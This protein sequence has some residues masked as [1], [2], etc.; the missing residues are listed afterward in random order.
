MNGKQS[1]TIL[2]A[3]DHQLFVDGLVRILEEDGGYTVLGTC[4]SGQELLHLLNDEAPN[5]VMLDIQLG[6]MN[7][8]ELCQTIRLRFPEV[9]VLFISMFES[10][11]IIQEGE[12]AGASGFIPK[13]YD[14]NQVKEVIQRVLA[15][16]PVFMKA[17]APGD[18]A[19]PET[20]GI[21]L[22]TR[23]EKEIIAMIRRGLTSRGIAEALN[24]SEYTI[25]TH[26]RNIFRKLKLKSVAE[27]HAFVF[28][29]E[30]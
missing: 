15:G 17:E 21:L 4:N 30:G 6:N 22:L 24:L 25:E 12:D 23:R 26:R 14:A 7:G 1:Y 10:R 5:L 18:Q 29:Q 11:R 8:I 9:R 20:A 13:T 16:E 27:L 2:I 3:D 28:G 19:L